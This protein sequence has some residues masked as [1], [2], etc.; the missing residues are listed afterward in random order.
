MNKQL[1]KEGYKNTQLGT[2]H[3][4]RI[5]ILTSSI[6]QDILKYGWNGNDI[7]LMN[8]AWNIAQRW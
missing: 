5:N 6:W 7:A 1:N 2:V 8:V 3:K 4:H